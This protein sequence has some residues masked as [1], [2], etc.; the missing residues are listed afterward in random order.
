[1]NKKKDNFYLPHCCDTEESVSEMQQSSGEV[2]HLWAHGHAPVPVE[3]G[4][5]VCKKVPTK[6]H[7]ALKSHS[8]VDDLGKRNRATYK[9]HKLILKNVH[10][11]WPSSNKR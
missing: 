9:H 10:R 11:S 6:D 7:V 4:S 5:S 8:S 3:K 1:M 2:H